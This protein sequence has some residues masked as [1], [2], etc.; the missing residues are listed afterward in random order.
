MCSW[1][2]GC[3]HESPIHRMS[4]LNSNKSQSKRH[5]QQVLIHVRMAPTCNLTLRQ[6][7]MSN[8]LRCQN[9]RAPHCRKINSRSPIKEANADVVSR[10]LVEAHS[11]ESCVDDTRNAINSQSKQRSQLIHIRSIPTSDL[12]HQAVS[13]DHTNTHFLAHSID[14]QTSQDE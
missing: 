10:V 12:T 2:C 13:K 1:E 11:W 14:S 9:S 8:F 7:E 4:T 6:F 5:L 3:I